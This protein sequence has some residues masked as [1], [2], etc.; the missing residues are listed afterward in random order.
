[1][2]NENVVKLANS[3]N[4]AYGYVYAGGTREEYCL[5]ASPKNM[6]AFIMEHKGASRIVLTD[7]VDELLTDTIGPFLDCCPHKEL[8][9]ALVAELIPMQ[10]GDVPCPPSMSTDMQALNEYCNCYEAY[11]PEMEM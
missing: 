5:E 4:L 6:A 9:A 10:L 8:R 1:M 2:E 3:E 7:R 11:E